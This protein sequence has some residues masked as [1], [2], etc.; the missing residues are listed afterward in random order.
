MR[1]ARGFSCLTAI[2]V[3]FAVNPVADWMILAVAALMAVK[4]WTDCMMIEADTAML[5]RLGLR[6]FLRA[7]SPVWEW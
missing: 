1:K 5:T 7:A 3:A 6:V 4:E 2:W